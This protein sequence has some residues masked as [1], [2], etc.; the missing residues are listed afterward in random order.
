MKHKQLSN[1]WRKVLQAIQARVKAE[2][3]S[4]P[5]S[6]QPEEGQ[7][8]DYTAAKHIRDTLA[9]TANKSLLGGLKGTAGLWDKIV[10]AY[11]ARSELLTNTCMC[12]ASAASQIVITSSPR[13]VACTWFSDVSNTIRCLG[14]SSRDLACR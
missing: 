4:L 6:L 14:I 5:A 1:A 10:K 12:F 9:V 3:G 13:A 11:Q 2:L 7:A 8:I